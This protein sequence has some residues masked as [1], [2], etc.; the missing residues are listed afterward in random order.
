ML[1]PL[2]EGRAYALY[3]RGVE[4]EQIV[5]DGEIFTVS[6]TRDEILLDN[7][8]NITVNKVKGE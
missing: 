4:G 6:S 7:F 5:A 3:M 8:K 2:G 1:P